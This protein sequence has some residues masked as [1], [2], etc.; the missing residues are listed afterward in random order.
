MRLEM[1]PI[2]LEH[3]PEA[4]SVGEFIPSYCSDRLKDRC[5]AWTPSYPAPQPSGAEN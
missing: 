1:V 5:E 3:I 2:G 4:V